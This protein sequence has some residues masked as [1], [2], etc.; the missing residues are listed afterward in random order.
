[1]RK[2]ISKSII[3]AH[4]KNP[5]QAHVG[6]HNPN[7]QV[8]RRQQCERQQFDRMEYAASVSVVNLGDDFHDITQDQD[9]TI[10]GNTVKITGADIENLFTPRT[11]STSLPVNTNSAVRF[12]GI[13]LQ[14]SSDTNETEQQSDLQSEVDTYILSLKHTIKQH[15]E[16]IAQLRDLAS[17]KPVSNSTSMKSDGNINVQQ[18]VPATT[19]NS[20]TTTT[21]SS[22]IHE[23]ANSAI[24]S[25]YLKSNATERDQILSHAMKMNNTNLIARIEASKPALP[26]ISLDTLTEKILKAISSKYQEIGFQY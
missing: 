5:G 8:D 19:V 3:F 24:I 15:E 20:S 14:M 13:N 25:L 16:S 6:H 11:S 7:S 1:M 4:N 2:N 9:A 17:F 26:K 18:Q 23:S 22:I 10:T 12:T 21:A